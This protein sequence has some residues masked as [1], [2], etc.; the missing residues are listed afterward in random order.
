MDTAFD[1]Y[2]EIV[3]VLFAD[4]LDNVSVAWESA[5]ISGDAF[6]FA[7]WRILAEDENVAT[8]I[9]LR[10]LFHGGS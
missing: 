2:F 6:I 4:M 9:L 3:V 10:S 8:A 1:R 5:F 7:C